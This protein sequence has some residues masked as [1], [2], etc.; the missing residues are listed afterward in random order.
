MGKAVE[1]RSPAAQSRS[2]QEE[3]TWDDLSRVRDGWQ[4]IEAEE[5]RLLSQMT[6]QDS[7]RQLLALQRAVVKS[8][9]CGQNG[10]S[11]LISSARMKM[12][13]FEEWVRQVEPKPKHLGIVPWNENGMRQ[14][15]AEVGV[16]HNFGRLLNYE[17][18]MVDQA[19][20]NKCLPTM[21]SV[22]GSGRTLGRSSMHAEGCWPSVHGDRLGR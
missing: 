5:T 11:D 14:S 19:F 2:E 15:T 18:K 12:S 8:P 7:L 22:L 9:L 1:Q 10:L 16:R 4:E 3:L 20:T 6:I 17:R 21:R 13:A